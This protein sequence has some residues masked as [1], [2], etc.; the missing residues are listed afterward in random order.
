MLG[1]VFPVNTSLPK[2]SNRMPVLIVCC[3]ANDLYQVVFALKKYRVK[4]FRSVPAV[5]MLST[6]PFGC[7]NCVG[8]VENPA[9]VM[10]A[11]LLELPKM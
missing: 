5:E 9:A 2:R 7:W 3:P 11:S 8:T 4:M 1:L 10:V 6:K